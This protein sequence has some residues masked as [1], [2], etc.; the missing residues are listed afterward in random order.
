MTRLQSGAAGGVGSITVQLARRP[1]AEVIGI[2]GRTN[3]D[4]LTT[5]GIKPVTYGDG[6]GQSA[7]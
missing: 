2:A 3:H 5:H 1:G 7:A 4:W 6:P